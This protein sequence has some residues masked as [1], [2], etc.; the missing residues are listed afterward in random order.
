MQF[1]LIL[2]LSGLQITTLFWFNSRI[3]T[4]QKQKIEKMTAEM[5]DFHKKNKILEFDKIIQEKS[6]NFS[7]KIEMQEKIFSQIISEKNKMVLF[8]LEKKFDYFD[9]LF[10]I[11]TTE[12]ENKWK[13][14][15]EKCLALI[16]AKFE[17]LDQKFSLMEGKIYEKI[18]EISN[19]EYFCINSE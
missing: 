12:F 17:E 13:V 19:K 3:M 7:N 8:N 5:F 4:S 1:F 14:D 15:S 6:V 2:Y 11:K 18:Y 10:L 16:K 9:K